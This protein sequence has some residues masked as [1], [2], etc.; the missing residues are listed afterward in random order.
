MEKADHL[1]DGINV[2]NVRCFCDLK[3]QVLRRNLIMI[4]QLCDPLCE[5]IDLAEMNRRHIQ[6]ERQQRKSVFPAVSHWKAALYT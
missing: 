3:N 6:R 1:V 5:R 4:E 2:M